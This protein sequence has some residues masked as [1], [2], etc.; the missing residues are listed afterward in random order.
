M[1]GT[2]VR[3]RVTD[4]LVRPVTPDE[5]LVRAARAGDREA[6]TALATRYEKS[7]LAAGLGILRSHAD[8]RDAAQ[9]T[10]LT[11]YQRL[12]QLGDPRKFAPWL[13]KIMRR[14]ALRIRKQRSR[15][16][17]EALP[18]DHPAPLD[19][20]PMALSQELFVLIARLPK[21]QQ[22]MVVLRYVDDFST[23]EIARI[24]SLPLGTVTK[25][26]SRALEKLRGW[27][28]QEDRHG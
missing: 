27:L 24:T 18:A 17:A 9:E 20:G 6:F 28:S 19:A 13:L 10:L 22:H 26:L 4:T 14:A 15:R 12:N 8:A 11:A 16:S 3:K 23:P 2:F 5:T 1:L 7:L 21:G 25:Q